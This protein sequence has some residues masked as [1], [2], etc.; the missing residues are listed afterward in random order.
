MDRRRFLLTSLAGALGAPLTAEAQQR[1]KV[2]RIGFMS[3]LGSRAFVD[4]SGAFRKGLRE[5]GY[6]E[7]QN[8]AIECRD[9]IGHVDRFPDL[10]RELVGLNLDVLVTEGTPAS[11]A[12]KGA[13]TTI[14]V[15]M[16]GVL[17]PEESGL[18]ANLARPGADVTGPS[19]LS[20]LEFASKVLQLT[21]N[22]VP[23]VS[24]IAVLRDSP[25][26]VHR[27]VD[28]SVAAAA[29]GLGMKPQFV[30]VRGAAD[31]H[32]A[33]A[34]VV[35]YGA[36]ALLVYPVPLTAGQIRSIVEFAHI[37]RLPR[38]TF[39]EGYVEQGFLLFYGTRLSEEYR[40]A[41]LYVDKILKGAKPGDLPI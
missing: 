39:W 8:L 22:V 27:R 37:K 10:A 2:Y 13:T 26:P 4:P 29:R 21:N 1:G 25:N 34:A 33:F 9:A 20:T 24:R 28:N 18:V 14:P 19:M 38:V 16:F 40:R 23:H 15:V 32:A 36:Q 41:G 31:L 17:D 35:D 30:S 12:A 3:Y 6:V 7:G 5:L 11:L